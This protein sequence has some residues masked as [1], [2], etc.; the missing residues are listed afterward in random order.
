MD[1]LKELREEIDEIDNK[2]TMLLHKRVETAKKIGE[3]KKERG[4]S[5]KDREREKK[6]IE[7][8]VDKS[9]LDEDFIKDIYRRVIDYCREN[10]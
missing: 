7:K 1:R 10:E 6:V 5:I 8:V 9:R 3:I 4:L 2:L